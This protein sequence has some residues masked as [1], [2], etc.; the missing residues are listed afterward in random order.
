MPQQQELQHELEITYEH[1]QHANRTIGHLEDRIMDLEIIVEDLKY[2]NNEL[3]HE[4]DSLRN[5][6]P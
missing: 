2:Y 4:V 5:Q 6:L 1:L 3:E